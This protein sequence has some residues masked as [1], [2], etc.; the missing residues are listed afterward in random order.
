MLETKELDM[1]SDNDTD[2]ENDMVTDRWGRQILMSKYNLG[3]VKIIGRVM[4]EA[5][6]KIGWVIN[7][8]KKRMG[9]LINKAMGIKLMRLRRQ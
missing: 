7:E 6:T 3:I 8:A 1:V 5:M 4:N 2:S 9:R